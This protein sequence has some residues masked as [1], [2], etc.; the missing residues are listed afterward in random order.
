MIRSVY[1][2]D[3]HLGSKNC[4]PKKVL[5]FLQSVE[6]E[7]L[8]LVGDFIDGWKLRK[9]TGNWKP[10][11]TKLI[12][13][14]LE[15]SRKGVNVYW[16]KGNH[17]D[18]LDHYPDFSIGNITI[19]EE[20]N[21]DGVLIIHGHQFDGLIKTAKW[22]YWIGSWAY[23]VLLT[24]N[25]FFPS[26]KGWSLSKFLKHKVKSTVNYINSF[27]VLVYRYAKSKECSTVITGH[28]HYPQ[29]RYFN[30]VRYLNCGDWVE[31][32]SYIVEYDTGKFEIKE[33]K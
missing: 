7:N 30:G 11:N 26:K 31:N 19:C 33:F 32:S 17:D 6:F 8:Y 10:N 27:E 18:F 25:K 15:L 16:I 5:R 23:D 22:L 13:Y 29:D 12:N 4:H 3:T 1:I 9:N 21:Q 28:I 20:I 24:L 14:I 2:S